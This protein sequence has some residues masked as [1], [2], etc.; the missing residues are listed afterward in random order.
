MLQADFCQSVT[1]TEMHKPVTFSIY[2]FPGLYYTQ[3]LQIRLHQDLN[4]SALIRDIF[5]AYT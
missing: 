4:L 3:V 2:Y 5:E 1:I